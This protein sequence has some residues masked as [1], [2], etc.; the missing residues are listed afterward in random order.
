VG[1]CIDSD[2]EGTPIVRVGGPNDR[3]LVVDLHREAFAGSMGVSLG[4]FYLRRFVSG[5]LNEPSFVLV[6]VLGD[7]AVGYALAKPAT[8]GG[9][10]RLA[11]WV[12]VA[13]LRRPNLLRRSDL[14]AE[15]RRQVGQLRGGSVPAR[16]PE[17]ATVSLTGIGVR[18]SARRS[19]VATALLDAYEAEARRRGFAE[20]RLTVYRSDDAPRRLYEHAGWQ[21]AEPSASE[22]TLVYRKT[23]KLSGD[24]S[25]QSTAGP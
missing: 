1:V 9:G 21:E 25:E 8:S 15:L 7:R 3:D 22:A 4:R 5:F 16:P 24:G 14:R 23:F 6:A 13:V 18:E 2:A 11:P 12:V 20:G 17:A 19:G 10:W